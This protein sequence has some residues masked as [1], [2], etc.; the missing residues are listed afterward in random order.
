LDGAVA[1][2]WNAEVLTLLFTLQPPLTEAEIAA[3]K[4]ETQDYRSI[5]TRR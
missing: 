2:K 3:G 1:K 4:K 5:A